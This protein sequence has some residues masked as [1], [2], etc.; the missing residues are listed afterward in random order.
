M[1]G[2]STKKHKSVD[3]FAT[4]VLLYLCDYTSMCAT[5]SRP[6]VGTRS[7]HRQILKHPQ[8]DLER[9]SD[10]ICGAFLFYPALTTTPPQLL[11]GAAAHPKSQD[12]TK[13][14]V[15]HVSAKIARPSYNLFILQSY[16][17]RRGYVTNEYQ[18]DRL[19]RSGCSF[20]ACGRGA[21]MVESVH[22]DTCYVFSDKCACYG[23]CGQRSLPGAFF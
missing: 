15:I 16:D 18:P 12:G 1:S 7:L 3:I 21:I 13:Y 17:S 22:E 9:L 20:S 2:K 14:R 6:I 8:K 10:N 23:I 19:L 5:N 4:N 11:H